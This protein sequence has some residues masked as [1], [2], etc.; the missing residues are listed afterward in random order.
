MVLRARLDPLI[1]QRLVNMT[2]Y[3]DELSSHLVGSLDDYLRDATRRRAVERLAQVV[4]ENAI[5]VN[6]LILEREGS[7]PAPTA[8]QSF[9][10][11]HNLGAIDDYVLDRFQRYVGMRNRIVHDYDRLDNRI[12]YYSARRLINDARQYIR[13]I[14]AYL[15]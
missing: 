4:V 13:C 9:E 5:D 3:A 11:V 6:N 14:Y 2:A 15:P 7:A 12:I 10:D 1:R 8:R